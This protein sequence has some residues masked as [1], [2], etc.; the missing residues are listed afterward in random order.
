MEIICLNLRD[1]LSL[2]RSSLMG[3]VSEFVREEQALK[4]RVSKW[5]ELSFNINDGAKAAR[6]TAEN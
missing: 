6:N 1:R 3:T 5:Q 2:M 4:T